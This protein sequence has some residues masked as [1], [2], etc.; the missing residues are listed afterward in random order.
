MA[1][2]EEGAFHQLALRFTDP[3]QHDYEV[4]RGIMLADETVA[5]RSRATGLDRATVGEKA[6]RFVQHGMLGLVDQRTTT[7]KGQHP[8]PAVVA[9]YIL[10]LKQLYPAIHDREIARIIGRK[11]GYKTNHHTVRSFLERHPIPVQLPL[12]LT[13]FHQFDDAYR[14]RWTVVRLH[15]EGWQSQ[16]IAKCLGL[17]RKHVWHILK[18]FERDGFAGLEDK[19]TRP[20]THPANQLSLPFLSEV[21]AVQREYPR[22]GRF[23]L[24]GVLAKRTGHAPS[25]TTIG[26]AMAINRRLHGAP[27]AWVT[28][29]PAPADADGVSKEMPYAPTHRHHYWF[30]DF[31]YLVRLEDTAEGDAHGEAAAEG[32]APAERWAYSLCLFEGYSRKILAGLATEYQDTI[33]V[34][35]LLAAAL[36][37]YGRPAGIV[38]DNGAV[39]TSAA[40]EG[41]L[42]ELEIAVCHIEK[43]KPW[44]NLAEAQFK[45]QLRLAE[46]HFEQATDFVALQD[47]HAAFVEEFNTTPHWAHRERPDGLHTPEEVLSWMRG[48]PLEPERL[49]RALRHLQVERVVNQR[50]YVSVQRFY[51]YAERGLARARVSVWLYDGR[52]HIAHQETLLAH[53]SYQYDRRAR[54]IRGVS[55]PHLHRTGYASPQ[56]E[57]WELDDAQWRKVLPRPY[58][59]QAHPLDS[60]ARQLALPVVGVVGSVALSVLALVSA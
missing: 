3:V 60:G 8:Y 37:E 58:V 16:S 32:A 53:Y 47:R 55:E 12:P 35:Q 6:R 18:A 34:L 13:G 27:A 31:R 45:V 42:E 24:R 40:Y 51:M 25:E 44:E 21:L 46:A 9:G 20:P 23:R 59:R 33:A 29:R 50:G 26:R 36:A 28:D 22:A 10:Y 19:R 52:L 48:A 5:A 56:L 14:A 1:V 11:Y 4:I 57:L 30:I 17:S 49:Q 15:Y 54:R 7:L 39:F 41:L 2:S 38:S 43:G